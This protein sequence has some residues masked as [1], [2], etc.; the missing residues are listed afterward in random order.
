MMEAFAIKDKKTGFFLRPAFAQGVVAVTR[1]IT[2]M[3]RKPDSSVA[4]F[5]GD[6]AIYR[7]G[8]FDEVEG[9]FV[10]QTAP[11]FI[12]EIVSFIEPVGGVKNG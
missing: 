8:K 10:H 7:V 3:V 2:L 1:E 5:P 4:Q 9:V 6:F 12:A 11:E